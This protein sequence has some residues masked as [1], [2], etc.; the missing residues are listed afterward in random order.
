MSFLDD[1]LDTVGDA[2]GAVVEPIGDTLGRLMDDP[3][4][5]AMVALSAMA[6]GAGTALG[7]ALGLT[8]TAATVVGQAAINAAL[9]GG[10][11]KAAILSA[12]SLLWAK[13]L[14]LQRLLNFRTRGWIRPW[15]TPQEKSQQTPG[16]PQ[17]RA[18]TLCRHCFPAG[19][20]RLCRIS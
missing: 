14:A 10:D 18:V 15:R 7:A 11:A 12:A 6:P 20:R 13:S 16:S 4:Q 17:R 5:L 8:G 2:I 9:N 19:C 1:F 3:R